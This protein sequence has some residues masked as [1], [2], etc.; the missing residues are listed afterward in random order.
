VVTISTPGGRLR[1]NCSS[2]ASTA[3][4]AAGV[5]ALPQDDDAARDLALA[6]E[7]GDAAPQFGADLNGGDVAQRH[8]HTARYDLQGIARKSSR[9]PR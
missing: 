4:I 5:G 8:R 7:L 3:S 9:L 1:L 2:F 6:V